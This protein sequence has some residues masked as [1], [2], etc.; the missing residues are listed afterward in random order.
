MPSEG[1]IVGGDL[2][3]S[4]VYNQVVRTTHRENWLCEDNN[5]GQSCEDMVT[6]L[7]CAVMMM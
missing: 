7:M 1:I 4:G 6:K 2:S 3:R 5:K